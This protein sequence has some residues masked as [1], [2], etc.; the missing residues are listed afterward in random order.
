MA[1]EFGSRA[2]MINAK[3]DE[4]SRNSIW[5]EHCK[6]ELSHHTLNTNFNISNPLKMPTLPEKPNYVLPNTSMSKQDVEVANATLREVCSIKNAEVPPPEK[7]ESPV[8]AGNEYG[9][10]SKVNLVGKNQMFAHPRS[11]CEITKYADAYYAMS[12]TT[13]FS[14]KDPGAA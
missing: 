3:I 2:D 6:K 10:H 14:R 1:K 13:P 8:T 5:R 4:V 11:A 12:G 7:Y 9:W